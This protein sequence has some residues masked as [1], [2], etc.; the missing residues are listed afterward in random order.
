M[1]IGL[2]CVCVCVFKKL[3]HTLT[4]ARTSHCLSLHFCLILFGPPNFFMSLQKSH[5]AQSSVRM[6]GSHS[7][8]MRAERLICNHI[9]WTTCTKANKNNPII[10]RGDVIALPATRADGRSYN[11]ACRSPAASPFRLRPTLCLGFFWNDVLSPKNHSYLGQKKRN[12]AKEKHPFLKKKK[13]SKLLSIR[14]KKL[15]WAPPTDT[16]CDIFHSTTP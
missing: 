13:A 12:L 8:H 9:Q 6:Q 16:H 3:R 14:Q 7:P 11:P 2:Q 1:E 5:W 15:N 10:S 4:R